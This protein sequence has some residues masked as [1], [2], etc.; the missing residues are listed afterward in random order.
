MT[1]YAYHE[2][3]IRP[4]SEAHIS[5]TCTT[6]HYGIGCFGGLR[7]FWSDRDKQLYLFRPADH[8]RRLLNSAKF[9]MSDIGKTNAELVALTVEL[10]RKEEWKENVYIR[11]I[12]YKDDGVFRVQLH[13]STDKLAIFSHPVGAY[14][15]GDGALKVG[16]S[17]WRR[18]D[19]NA[20]PARG[21]I[22]GTY[23]NSALAKTEAVM[24]G[25]QEALVLNQDGHVSEASAANLFV[26]RDGVVITP[27]ITD[28]VLEGITRKTIIEFAREDMGLE[29]VERSIDRSELYLVDEAFFCGTGVGVAA[30]GSIDHRLIDDGNTGPI[31]AKMLAHYQN[32]V[33]GGVPKYK[34]W[35]TPV[36]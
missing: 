24:N 17:T 21:K 18:V 29:V 11:P 32:V 3:A 30:I 36:Y 27:P 25:F 28:N 14:I 8:Y 26:V 13:D 2:G 10:L 35:L 5:V 19:D 12:I 15:K 9:L 16:F 20:I 22:S 7:A 4:I 33:T 1:K 31:A 6:F 23:I 34:S